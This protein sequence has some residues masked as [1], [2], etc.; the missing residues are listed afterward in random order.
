MKLSILRCSVLFASLAAFSPSESGAADPPASSRC[1]PLDL[2]RFWVPDDMEF[3]MP[4][5]IDKARKINDSGTCVV[6]GWFGRNENKFYMTVVPPGYHRIG[7]V[8]SFTLKE[9]RDKEN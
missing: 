4:D 9:L 3:A 7:K 8:R 1:D 5:F 2:T 6:D